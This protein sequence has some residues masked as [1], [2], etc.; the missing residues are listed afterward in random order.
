MIASPIAHRLLLASAVAAMALPDLAQAQE[1]DPNTTVTN[2]SRPEYDP[3][4]IRAGSFLMF[5]EL[6]VTEAYSDNVGLDEDDEQSDFVTQ[7]QPTLEFVSQWSRHLLSL[8]A[9]AD[10]AIHADESGEDYEDLFAAAQG[11]VDVSRQTNLAATALVRQG[12]EGR[13]DPEDPDADDLT[14]TYSFGGGLDLNHQINRLGF[15]VGVDV[16]RNTYDNNGQ[17][18]R[19]ANIYDFL[20]R[21]S[22]ELSPRFNAFIEGRY[23]VEDRDD[24]VDDAGIERDTDGYEARLGAALDVTAVLF[25]EAFVGYRV[26]SFDES[27]FDDE[28]GVSFGVDLNW[29]PSQLT[30]V[31]FS[32]QR[33]FRP[34]DEGGAASNFRTEFGITID[35]ELLR[36]LIVDG[37]ASYQN[38]DFRGD[39]REDDTY[40]VGAGLTYWLNRN[41]SLTAGYDHAERSSNE[42]GQDYKVNEVLVG[43]T[44]RL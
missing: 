5:P 18:D 36:N 1:V 30:S 23:N 2:R 20:L 17:D 32:G 22:Y 42:V 37:R 44:L 9:G 3:L 8:E 14:D 16:V 7:I 24:D 38:D 25:G 34:T 39:D 4:G 11:R 28:E 15:T 41:I 29:N 40:S 6:A 33:D 27:D 35:H 26:Q 19:D 43:L 21:T 10:I 31:G 12:H 13:D